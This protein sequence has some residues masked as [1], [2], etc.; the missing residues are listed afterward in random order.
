VPGKK[1]KQMD[2]VILVGG[3]IS[4]ASMPWGA[5]TAEPASEMKRGRT[6]NLN[7]IVK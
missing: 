3:T 4:E 2:I 1:G 6:A 7:N 5:A